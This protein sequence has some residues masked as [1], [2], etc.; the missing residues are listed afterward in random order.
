MFHTLTG[1]FIIFLCMFVI[2]FAFALFMTAL[3][4]WIFLTDEEASETTAFS[5][6][7]TAYPYRKAA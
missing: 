5:E 2:V 3:L 1:S 7:S 6:P 4:R